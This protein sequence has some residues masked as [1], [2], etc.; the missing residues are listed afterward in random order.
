MDW[1]S[2]DRYTAGHVWLPRAGLF[3]TA[4]LAR[5]DA[6]TRRSIARSVTDAFFDQFPAPAVAPPRRS[7]NRRAAAL[8]R[9]M[10]ADG[11][12]EQERIAQ[13]LANPLSYLWLLFT[14]NDTI[15]YQGTTVDGLGEDQLLQN[16]TLFMPV[17]SMQMTENWK[18]IFRPV[19]PINNFKT[20]D[21]VNL[22]INNPG[23][24]TGINL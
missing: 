7:G 17:L 22:A 11:M 1:P 19:I 10:Q 18:M 20:V 23:Q 5:V 16:T 14:Q 21:N 13:A 2:A 12:T 3:P 4:G 24:V 8:A 6:T 9:A 15:S